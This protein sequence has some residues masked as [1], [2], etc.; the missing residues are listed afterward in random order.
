MSVTAPTTPPADSTTFGTPP[1]SANP[2]NF[3]VLGDAFLGLFPA[4]QAFL[5]SL[6]AWIYTTA[7]ATY[8][9]ALSTAADATATAANA[10]SVA[11]YANAV[12][13]VSGTT[14]AMG[15]VRYSPADRR[16]Y[17]RLTAGAGATDPSGDATNWALLN[18]ERP[19]VQVAGTTQTALA[20]FDYELRNVAAT[21]VTLPASPSSGDPPIRLWIENG[22]TTNVINPSG[23][24]ING[25]AGN[26]TYDIVYSNPTFRF[27]NGTWRFSQ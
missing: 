21:T 22:L 15:D 9:N 25:V 27:V 1:S 7:Q 6:K 14:Y 2:S 10:A 11:I 13:W 19:L 18:T 8:T 12:A 17:R 3:D 24:T 23:S 4:F 5:T 16:L 20:G 26:M